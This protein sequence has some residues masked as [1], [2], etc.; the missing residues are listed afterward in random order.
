MG[1]DFKHETALAAFDLNLREF[2]L[3]MNK[4]AC[5]CIMDF[6][7]SNIELN[8]DIILHSTYN[9]WGYKKQLLVTSKN[10]QMCHR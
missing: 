9:I 4:T 2:L 1:K 8:S 6:A 7:K 10:N 5:C 3:C